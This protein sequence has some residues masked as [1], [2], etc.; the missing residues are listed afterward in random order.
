MH[1]AEV[2]RAETRRKP[3]I[4]SATSRVKRWPWIIDNHTSGGNTNDRRQLRLGARL[5]DRYVCISARQHDQ[6]LIASLTFSLIMGWFWF[7]LLLL[8][9]SLAL[10]TESTTTLRHTSTITVVQTIYASAAV[11]TATASVTTDEHS[12]TDDAVFDNTVLDITN[13]VRQ[14]YNA[15]ALSWNDTLADYAQAWS[16]GCKFEHSV[17]RF[18]SRIECPQ[19]NKAGTRTGRTAKTL[20]RPT[21]RLR[22]PSQPG[23]TSRSTSTSRIQASRKPRATSRRWFGKVP[24]RWDAGG[25]VAAARAEATTPTAGMSCVAIGLEATSSASLLQMST[26]RWMG[27]AALGMTRA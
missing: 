15:S 13:T 5:L 9:A 17:R 4:A 12:Y 22:P 3:R 23:P 14:N 10:P 16:E 26:R 25:P 21:P 18:A 20:P 24:R 19:T 1:C 2:G 27:A 11:A 8:S 7:N 6:T